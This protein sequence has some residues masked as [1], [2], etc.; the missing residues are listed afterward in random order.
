MH[1]K[2][3][4][5]LQY[6]AGPKTEKSTLHKFFLKKSRLRELA[7][8]RGGGQRKGNREK[9]GTHHH[10]R[11]KSLTLRLL[12]HFIRARKKKV[13]IDK[14][15]ERKLYVSQGGRRILA[16]GENNASFF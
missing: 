16:G 2:K 1:E 7:G 6:R 8:E 14:I 12:D 3:K 4:K 10:V 11:R 13:D 5:G 9:K 15:F